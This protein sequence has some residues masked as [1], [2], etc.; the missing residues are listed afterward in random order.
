QV[1]VQRVC[2]WRTDLQLSEYPTL[3]RLR[4]ISLSLPTVLIHEQQL[5]F[6]VINALLAVT[7]E[8]RVA[9]P[10]QPE[11]IT[12][13]NLERDRFKRALMPAHD[14]ELVDWHAICHGNLRRRVGQRRLR[15]TSMGNR[16]QCQGRHQRKRSSQHQ[17]ACF[18]VARKLIRPEPA[19]GRSSA[20][21]TCMPCAESDC[22]QRK[23]ASN[24]WFSSWTRTDWSA[25][26]LILCSVTDA[27][28]ADLLRPDIQP[29]AIR[30]PPLLRLRP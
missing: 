21:T 5:V 20:L 9:E 10:H 2:L 27:A 23:A 15:G 7:L 11:F 19:P 29:P 30:R 17:S 25:P 28:A 22:S 18:N 12:L 6:L 3:S 13:I 8:S 26:W 14:R 24:D 1:K 16:S 4:I